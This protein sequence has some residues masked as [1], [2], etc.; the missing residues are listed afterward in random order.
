[1]FAD[2]TSVKTCEVMAE[3][4]L[5]CPDTAKKEID[6]FLVKEENVVRCFDLW[7]KSVVFECRA[8]QIRIREGNSSKCI[9]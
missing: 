7:K 4:Y 1:M 3:L 9:L 6:I 5:M 2:E 8:F